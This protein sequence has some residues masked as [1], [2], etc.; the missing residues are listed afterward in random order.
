MHDPQALAVG[1]GVDGL[2]HDLDAA[3]MMIDEMAHE[4][5]VIARHEDDAAALAHPAQDLLHHIVVLLRPVPAP[6]QLPAI[7]DVADQIEMI[8]RI[9]P[10]EGQQRLGLAALG[11]E[12]KIGDENAAQPRTRLAVRLGGGAFTTTL[13]QI[14]GAHQTPRKCLR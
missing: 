2:G 9:G 4:L 8:A 3:K 5:V 7:D 6:A 12:V 10:Q 11:P 13:E 1:G 14:G